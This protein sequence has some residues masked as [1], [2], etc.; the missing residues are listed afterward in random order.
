[1][2]APCINVEGAAKATFESAAASAEA[3]AHILVVGGEQRTPEAVMLVAIEALKEAL[4]AP[5]THI[6]IQHCQLTGEH[7]VAKE[8]DA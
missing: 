3:V 7:Y 6:T 5:D 4:R 2:K 8:G 1:M